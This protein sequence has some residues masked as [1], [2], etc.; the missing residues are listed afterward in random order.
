MNIEG[1]SKYANDI[2]FQNFCSKFDNLGLC[3]TWGVENSVFKT[4]LPGFSCF[5]YVRPKKK[6]AKRGSGGVSVFIKDELL[7]TCKFKRIFENFHN[8][9]VLYCRCQYSFEIENAIC[10]FLHLFLRN[11]HQYIILMT[12]MA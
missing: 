10:S 12:T 4:I 3:E 11:T 5:D 1:L 6:T 2:N 8:C 9:V 7:N